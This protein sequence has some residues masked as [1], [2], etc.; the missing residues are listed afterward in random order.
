M[1]IIADIEKTA[2][3]LAVNVLKALEPIVIELVK[4]ELESLIPG[5]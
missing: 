1:S 5:L 4:K 3:D 2:E